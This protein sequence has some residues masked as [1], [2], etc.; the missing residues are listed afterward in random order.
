MQQKDASSGEKKIAFVSLES[1]QERH[2]IIQTSLTN[3]RGKFVIQ[4]R[5]EELVFTQHYQFHLGET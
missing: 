2:S 1:L 4:L 5:R 3:F